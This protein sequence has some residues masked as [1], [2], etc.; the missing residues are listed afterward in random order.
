MFEPCWMM[1]AAETAVVGNGR[2]DEARFKRD[3]RAGWLV[4]E[5]LTE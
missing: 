1:G 3:G 5:V 2:D 4:S